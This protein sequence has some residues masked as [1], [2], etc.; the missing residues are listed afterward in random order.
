MGIKTSKS[1]ILRSKTRFWQMHHSLYKLR[2]QTKTNWL[3]IQQRLT[4]STNG[5]HTNLI[6]MYKTN[7]KFSDFNLTTTSGLLL[8]NFN[9]LSQFAFSPDQN[10]RKFQLS[11]INLFICWSNTLL[12]ERFPGRISRTSFPY[13]CLNLNSKLIS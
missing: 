6:L 4:Y 8:N 10:R 5:E 1:H 7:S 13:L 11:Q 3:F 9:L 2:R 12:M